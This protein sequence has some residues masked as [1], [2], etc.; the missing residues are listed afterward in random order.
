MV[1][2]ADKWRSAEAARWQREAAERELQ[3]IS[4]REALMN[5]MIARETLAQ[6]MNAMLAEQYKAVMLEEQRTAIE[7]DLIAQQDA[8]M[9]DGP[10]RQRR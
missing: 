8:A 1:L 3:E 6:E 10:H 5:D 2:T 7:A 4:R 9:M